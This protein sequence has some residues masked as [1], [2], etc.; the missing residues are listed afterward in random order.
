MCM[1]IHVSP[2]P[3]TVGP[4]HIYIEARMRVN[5]NES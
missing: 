4:S 1:L 3:T 2:S 5:V